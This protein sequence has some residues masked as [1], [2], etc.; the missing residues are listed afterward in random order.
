MPALYR[1]RE[2]GRIFFDTPNMDFP[3]EVFERLNQGDYKIVIRDGHDMLEEGYTTDGNGNVIKVGA[4]QDQPAPAVEEEKPKPKRRGRPPA[5]P[6]SDPVGPPVD[7][8]L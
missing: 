4:T 8:G 7:A 6:P 5:T 3:I 2:N 1:H